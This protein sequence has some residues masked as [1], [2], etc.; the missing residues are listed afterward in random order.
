MEVYVDRAVE[1]IEYGSVAEVSGDK[2][3]DYAA[4]AQASMRVTA[5]AKATEQIDSASSCGGGEG[6]RDAKT[7]L[8]VQTSTLPGYGT[9]L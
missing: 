3:P 4:F 7:Q 1:S 9:E 2:R 5:L 6:V 8:G